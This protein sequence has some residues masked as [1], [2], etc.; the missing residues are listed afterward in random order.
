MKTPTPD[1]DSLIYAGI[2]A[3]GDDYF[4]WTTTSFGSQI[5]TIDTE[6]KE[7]FD[8]RFTYIRNSFWNEA[9]IRL[10]GG[11]WNEVSF[12]TDNTFVWPS[13]ISAGDHTVDLQFSDEAGHWGNIESK[14]F[15]K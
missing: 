15:T 11:E 8:S 13:T 3:D 10:D 9:R 12:P 2:N 14:D 7:E 4:N 1:G 5:G 6:N